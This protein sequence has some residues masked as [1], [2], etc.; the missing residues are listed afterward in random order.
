M[1]HAIALAA[2]LAALSLAPL[3]RAD[4]PPD[5]VERRD[6]STGPEFHVGAGARGLLLPDAGYQPYSS[7][8]VMFQLALTGGITFLRAGNV[9]LIAFAEWD[10][11]ETS[12]PARS[13]QAGLTMHRLGGGIEARFGIGRRFYLGV[14]AAPAALNLLG[15]LE[16]PGMSESLLARPWTWALD[17][18]G[19]AGL[20]LGSVAGRRAPVR[21]WLGAEV[22][23]AFAGKA[24]MAFAPDTDSSDTRHFGTVMLPAFQPSGGVSRLSLMM[25]F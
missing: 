7:N 14:K 16:E 18:T 23:Y 1:K 5:Q 9:S 3:A 25:S 12:A 22:G 13:A 17:T 24:T 6:A 2:A 11:G 10:V 4:P 19:T 8:E 20:L 15:S 21:F